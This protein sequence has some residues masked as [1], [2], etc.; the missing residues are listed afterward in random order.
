M[1]G[2]SLDMPSET[3]EDCAGSGFSLQFQFHEAEE[4]TCFASSGFCLQGLGLD[5]L[6]WEPTF[7]D[8]DGGCGQDVIDGGFVLEWEPT[9]LADDD[10]G[11]LC[12]DMSDAEHVSQK[13]P[14]RTLVDNNQAIERRFKAFSW[15]LTKAISRWGE[16]F[17]RQRFNKH[18]HVESLFTGIGASEVAIERLQATVS[19]M[20]G[21]SHMK[22]TFGAAVDSDRRCQSFLSAAFPERCIFGDINTLVAASDKIPRMLPM[23]FC[24]QHCKQCCTRSSP[25]KQTVRV[26]FV[27]GPCQAHT[28]M[29]LQKRF[30]DPRTTCHWTARDLVLEEQPDFIFLENVQEFPMDSYMKTF[31][32]TYSFKGGIVKPQ[33]IGDPM[34][35]ERFM[36]AGVL[37][38]KWRWT[39]DQTLS[40]MLATFN[41]QVQGDCNSFFHTSLSLHPEKKRMSSSSARSRDEYMK[42][43]SRTHRGLLFDLTQNA[44]KRP[45]TNRVDGS[46]PAILTRSVFYSPSHNA[47]MCGLDMLMAMGV[48]VTELASRACGTDRWL[49]AVQT[50]SWTDAALRHFAG[51]GLHVTSMGLVLVVTILCTESCS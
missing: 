13:G 35:R 4:T 22:V 27:T 6:E 41:R 16:E 23:A 30:S 18:L 17:V 51:N 24:H 5:G 19:S 40:E 39:S 29:G 37:N 31:E 20:W 49:R 42:N 45:R 25:E 33:N 28:R 8:H 43:F 2:F 32:P 50:Q 1:E 15:V 9:F 36:A 10:G 21:D 48:P 11:S 38:K 44:N 14:E 47:M 26:K 34:G 46:L 7:L 3:K 12:L